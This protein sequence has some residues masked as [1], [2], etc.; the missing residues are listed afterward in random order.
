MP[1]QSRGEKT[2][3]RIMDAAAEL[4]EEVGV[5]DITT[6]LICKKAG[7]T[8]PALYRYFSNK[9]AVLAA[10]GARLMERQNQIITEVD[11]AA[12]DQVAQTEALLLN[13]VALT[14]Q[15]PGGVWITRALRAS[16]SLADIRSSSHNWAAEY[17]VSQSVA[18][19]VT[20]ELRRKA[21]L[22]VEF[23]YAFIEMALE[24]NGKDD[25]ANARDTA[26]VVTQLTQQI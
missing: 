6:N 12:K 24:S 20:E 15:E 18:S 4:L 23:G 19:P 8:P 9:H 25:A 5:E 3:S 17:I 16:P 11:F 13:T 1:A 10:L 22:A 7:L 2:K 14:R 21:R 26:K